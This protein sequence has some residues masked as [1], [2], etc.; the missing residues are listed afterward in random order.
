MCMPVNITILNDTVFEEDETFIIVATYRNDSLSSTE[1]NISVTITILDDECK[2][3]NNH[4]SC[5]TITYCNNIIMVNYRCPSNDQS[6]GYECERECWTCN[7]V[8]YS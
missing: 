8:W 2:P 6:F 5:L 3:L 7:C 1:N 4:S